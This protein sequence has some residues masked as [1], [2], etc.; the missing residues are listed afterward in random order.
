MPRPRPAELAPPC[1]LRGV[2]RVKRRADPPAA[3]ALHPGTVRPRRGGRAL[4]SQSRPPVL[5]VWRSNLHPDLHL[6]RDPDPDPARP[7]PPPPPGPWTTP[8]SIRTTRAWRPWRRPPTA[9]SAPA[10]SPAASSTAPC[11]LPSPQRGHLA[12]RS[13]P[14]T[15]RLA[16]YATTSPRPIRQTPPSLT[17]TD[18][19]KPRETLS[20]TRFLSA[21]M[22]PTLTPLSVL[23]LAA[24]SL[25][26]KEIA[27]CPFPGPPLPTCKS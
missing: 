24:K 5:G 23:F 4:S 3:L 7:P 19:P 26:I 17:W 22:N 16:P 8:T 6:A 11:G 9:T 2:L 1:P 25:R 18:P 20:N 12:P 10:A 13:A 27:P 14:P 21:G 15:A